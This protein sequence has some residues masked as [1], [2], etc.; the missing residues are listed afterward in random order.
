MLLLHL[1]LQV[2][3]GALGGIQLLLRRLL[4]L[5]RSSF[6]FCQALALPLRCYVLGLQVLV[7]AGLFFAV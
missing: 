3:Q 7:P 6:F 4:P 5:D 1:F 2:L